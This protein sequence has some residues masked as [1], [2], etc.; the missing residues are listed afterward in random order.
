MFKFQTIASGYGTAAGYLYKEVDGKTI[1]IGGFNITQDNEVHINIDEGKEL[2]VKEIMLLFS[3]L[4][5]NDDSFINK[6]VFLNKV[7]KLKRV[8]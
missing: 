2:S 1:N 6:K 7:E 4:M 8:D 5:Q 3:Q